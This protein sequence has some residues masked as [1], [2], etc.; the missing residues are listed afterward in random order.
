MAVKQ[1]PKSLDEAVKCIMAHMRTIN[2]LQDE[3]REQYGIRLHVERVGF[4]NQTGEISVRNG[5]DKVAEALNET[6]KQSAYSRDRREFKHYGIEFYQYADDKTKHFT[7]AN[8]EKPKV[9]Y[10]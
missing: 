6:V 7:E 9:E 1:Q 4:F 2:K 10:V 5:I 8:E 3:I